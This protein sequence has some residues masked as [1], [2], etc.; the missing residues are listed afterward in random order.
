[1]GYENFP[2]SNTLKEL[3]IVSENE[4]YDLSSSAVG[5]SCFLAL[6]FSYCSLTIGYWGRQW[7]PF[8]CRCPLGKYVLQACAVKFCFCQFF[9]YLQTA[10]CHVLLQKVAL[11]TS[12]SNLATALLNIRQLYGTVRITNKCSNVSPWLDGATPANWREEGG[13]GA[14]QPC[15]RKTARERAGLGTILSP[16][17]PNNGYARLMAARRGEAGANGVRNRV[18]TLYRSLQ[19]D[20][21]SLACT[22]A[23]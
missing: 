6:A 17:I 18:Q 11:A 15:Q 10:L 2:L 8:L 19:H 12:P 13:G 22:A 1:M 21:M 16:P 14:G 7:V 23:P 5:D 4:S 3:W 20:S 9:D